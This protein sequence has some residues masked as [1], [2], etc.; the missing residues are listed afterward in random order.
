[1]NGTALFIK[2]T[3]EL[4]EGGQTTEDSH[5]GFSRHTSVLLPVLDVVLFVL[6]FVFLS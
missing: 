6:S 4:A 1:M 2:C 5:E 3:E